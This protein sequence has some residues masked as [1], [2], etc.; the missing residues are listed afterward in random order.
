[1]SGATQ[2][3]KNLRGGATVSPPDDLDIPDFPEPPDAADGT[4]AA[5]EPA[6]DPPVK[7]EDDGTVVVR[8]TQ[9]LAPHNGKGE[10]PLKDLTEVRLRKMFAGDL[11]ALD[12]AEGAVEQI[13]KLAKQLSG[14][15]ELAIRRLHA[16]DFA[17]VH[18]VVH[19][20]LG[21]FLGASRALSAL[22][23]G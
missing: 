9:P 20:R 5:D 23:L 4:D 15:P 2:K 22:S 7:L 19:G 12:K 14:L 11:M 10:D 16:D 17:R 3:R 1:M 6:E 8:L 13:I 18:G 21:N